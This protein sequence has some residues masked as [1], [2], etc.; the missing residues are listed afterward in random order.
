MQAREGGGSA[1][2]PRSRIDGGQDAG[3]EIIQGGRTLGGGRK[4]GS[5]GS[6]IREK[7]PA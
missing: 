3:L 7:K 5:G 2:A 4:R 6:A 1:A